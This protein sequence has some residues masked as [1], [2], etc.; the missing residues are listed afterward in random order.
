MAKED[1]PNIDTMSKAYEDLLATNA[2]LSVDVSLI[3]AV[4]GC[5]VTPKE[6]HHSNYVRR[7]CMGDKPFKHTFIIHRTRSCP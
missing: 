6:A 2:L 7:H 4:K 1:V 5:T 3:A